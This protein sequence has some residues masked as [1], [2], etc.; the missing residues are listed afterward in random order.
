MIFC[1]MKQFL[2]RRVLFCLLKRLFVDKKKRMIFSFLKKLPLGTF[3]LVK[4]IVY[5]KNKRMILYL[6]KQFLQG[7]VLFCLLKQ[8]FVDNTNE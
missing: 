4:T 3:L 6:L 5:R 2:Q 8:L 7:I 1:L